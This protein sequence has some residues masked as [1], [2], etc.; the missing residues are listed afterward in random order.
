MGIGDLKRFG[1]FPVANDL[2]EVVSRD[3]RGQDRLMGNYVP[4]EKIYMRSHPQYNEKWLQAQIAEDPRLLSLH[5][6]GRTCR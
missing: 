5:L 2:D 6:S 1:F 4:H 3:E